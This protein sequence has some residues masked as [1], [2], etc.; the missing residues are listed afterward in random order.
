MIEIDRSPIPLTRFVRERLGTPPL[1]G[2]AAAAERDEVLAIV[3]QIVTPR[4]SAGTRRSVY[5]N[6][7]AERNGV[8]CGLD[9]PP[10]SPAP[11]PT[12]DPAPAATDPDPFRR[13]EDDGGRAAD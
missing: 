4:L 13:W 10:P 9:T 5:R 7:P 12:P 8:G 6:R 3:A 1:P 2:T 11:Q